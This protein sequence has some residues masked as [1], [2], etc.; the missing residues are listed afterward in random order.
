VHEVLRPWWPPR[1][2]DLVIQPDDEPIY[3]D[4]DG[5]RTNYYNW[6]R[7]VAGLVRP[8]VVVE[9]GVRLGYSAWALALEGGTQTF[10]GLD[11]E[12]YIAGS[13]QRAREFLQWRYSQVLLHTVDTRSITTLRPFLLNY[14]PDVIHIDGDHACVHCR[15]D[16]ELAHEVLPVG[17]TLIVDDASLDKEPGQACQEF[18]R[19]HRGEYGYLIFSEEFTF[20][21]HHLLTRLKLAAENGQSPNHANGS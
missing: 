16:L 11:N 18:L 3:D 2:A 20:R 21:G 12:C 17:G 4:Q 9:I 10:I 5:G 15:H 13:N 19:D 8:R 6:Y 14:L 7:W 1:V